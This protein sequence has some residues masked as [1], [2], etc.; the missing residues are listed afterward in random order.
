M[1]GNVRSS[2][3]AAVHPFHVITS[4][5]ISL[6]LLACGTSSGASSASCVDESTTP[7]TCDDGTKSI[8]TCTGGAFG[9]CAC[10]LTDA[11]GVDV[12]AVTDAV[13]D[14]PNQ[15]DTANQPDT[16][17]DV[18]TG[19]ATCASDKDCTAAGKVCDPLTKVCVACLTD[20]ECKVNEHC[21]GLTCQGYT[22]CTNS[23][24]CKS[25]KGP[26]GL[27][28]P[29]CDQKIGECSS[30]LTAADCPAINDCV[31]KA[32]VPYKNCQNSTEC[33]KDEV[34]DKATSRCVQ[35]L[36]N[37]DCAAS[38]L[39]ES[40]K[41]HAFVP[42]SSDKQCTPLG[43]LCDS[44][45]GKCA[46]CL[47][48]SDCPAIYNCQKVGV[49][50][51]GQCVLD[52]CAQG[53]GACNN[54]QKVTC[55]SVGDGYGSP[56]ACGNGTTCVAPGGKPECKAWV[57]TPG[58]TCEGDKL[59]TCTDDGLEVQKSEDCAASGGKC[60]GG[61]CKPIVCAAGEKFCDGKAVKL[62]AADGLSASNLSTCAGDQYCDA[63]A[64]KAQICT[65]NQDGCDGNAI[66]TC[67]AAGSGYV[68]GTQQTCGVQK[69]VAGVCK[70]LVCA[71]SETYCDGKN[72]KV[73]AADGLSATLSKTCTAS[74]FCAAG[75]CQAQVCTPGT[76]V[77]DGSKPGTCK[78]D[79]S[80]IETF[81]VD[82]ATKSPAKVCSAGS[83][84]DQ[85]CTPA[86][87]FC[88]GGSL[89]TCSPDGTAV[90]SNKPC[91]VG[92]YCGTNKLG[93]PA[94][95]QDVCDP[96]KPACNGTK[97]TTCNADGSGYAGANTDCAASGKVCSAG[98]C[99]SLL[100]DPQD[101]LYCDG[102]N[103]MKC[104]AIGLSPS[105][106]QTCGAGY[107]CASGACSKQ[108]CTPDSATECVG[109]KPA[110]C[111]SDGSG[112]AKIGAD[113]GVGKTCQAGVCSA[114][115]C[116]NGVVEVGE[117]CDDGNAWPGD[118]CDSKCKC[119]LDGALLV[120][121]GTCTLSG[122][123]INPPNQMAKVNVPQAFAG[124]TSGTVEAWVRLDATSQY[125]KI[126]YG[127]DFDLQVTYEGDV[128][129]GSN[130]GK[131]AATW[132]K[133]VVF[134]Q[135]PAA[136]GSWHHFAVV[137]NA[138]KV[139]FF[140]DGQLQG[141]TTS[142]SATTVPAIAGGT[143]TIGGS[144]NAG[145]NSNE[146]LNGAI[147]AFRV[148]TTA[149]YT[150]NFQPPSAF[151]VDAN[152]LQV[153]AFDELAGTSASDSV[154]GNGTGTLLN[155]AGWTAAGAS[156]AC[157][158]ALAK[159]SCA[160]W[161]AS[162][163][164][165]PDGVYPIDPDGAGP[166][167]AANLFCDMKNG[168]LT[169]VANIYDSAGDDAPNDTSY[170]VSGWQQTSSGA[171]ASKASTVDRA[172][173]GGTGSA[174]VS[175]AFVEALKASAG[176]ANLKM[177]FVHKD[178]YDTVC[179]DSTDGSLTLVSYATG[180]PKLTPYVNDKLT[181]TFGRLAGLAGSVDG[182]DY[183]KMS[184]NADYGIPIS[185]DIVNVFG[186]GGELV[187]WGQPSDWFGVWYA[188]GGGVCFRPSLSASDELA[189]KDG[190]ADP[191]P[192][193]F[194]FR[195]YIGP[196]AKTYASCAARLAAEPGSG[197]GVYPID[198][199]GTGPIAAANL[200]CDMKNG[201][202]TLVANIYDSAGDD[203][204]NDTSYVVSGWQQTSSGAWASK[205]STVDRAWG[206]GTGSAAVSLAFVE[207]LKASAGQANLKM[208]FVHKDGYDTVC[209]DST[210]GSLT[211]V[212]YATGNP[213]LTPY[214]N[215]KLTYTFGRLA[216]LPGTTD[217]YASAT[218]VDGGDCVFVGAGGP[219]DFGSGKQ[220][221][222][223][224]VPALSLAQPW[225]AWGWAI[226]YAPAATNAYELAG[227]T[228][229]SIGSFV[230]DQG[231][232]NFGFRL[233]VGP[234]S[235]WKLALEENFDDGMSQGFTMCNGCAGLGCP[236]VANGKYVM[237][238]DWNSFCVPVD[239]TG[240]V[241]VA[242]EFDAVFS[243][244]TEFGFWSNVAGLTYTPSQP[245]TV[246]TPAVTPATFA[247]LVNLNVHVR[248]EYDVAKQRFKYFA[249]NTLVLDS[250]NGCG[251]PN[252]LTVI[253]IGSGEGAV[254]VANKS[255]IDNFK[256]WVR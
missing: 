215:D 240:T 60:V 26:D 241:G 171:W 106:L 217:G 4:I 29:I 152:A 64:C 201:G 223:S 249:D 213:K 77:C 256:A 185:A 208:C 164:S 93:D 233:Y 225:I 74:Q 41:C 191:S 137:F 82:C 169:L 183:T 85:I 255:T 8:K 146:Q 196:T 154:A 94:C 130:Q 114:Q 124:Q 57:C 203:A 66:A 197:D 14:T 37:N 18:P 120:Q 252:P 87:Q 155:G 242:Y 253:N 168:G 51:T 63:G 116:G 149:V 98:V 47:T 44:G 111:N 33:A 187:E 27:D 79:G 52:V 235:P 157:V 144:P 167:A 24:G 200:F 17:T 67:N 220:L 204:P 61:A 11:I 145:D 211:L 9:E 216:G 133:T 177:C 202:L 72:V 48:N 75:Q 134:S 212:S 139:L 125:G 224:W 20:A 194:G 254:G 156:A 232:G 86:S 243:A 53:Q 207:A 78:T 96:G 210:D 205:A 218:Y 3:Q 118:G 129:F 179:R 45:K 122:C 188:G 12:L 65:P 121:G 19:P 150:A 95:L 22:P 238:G 209:R 30:C 59:V 76:Q 102:Q 92:N 250:G 108:V 226:G 206:G 38:E 131:W 192:T 16:T 236:T 34:C 182:Y 90:T 165:L 46:Q 158:A 97:A 162:N 140:I 123:G 84:M 138:G 132:A 173:G 99:K 13:N 119:S 128:G 163:G 117:E 221:C 109:N 113:C 166:I 21:I 112:Y 42:C 107:Y 227:F 181:Y 35:C 101:P 219:A 153:L 50:K 237:N 103:V 198:P 148:S 180:N 73:C 55:N 228:G 141:Q 36:G 49:D 172:W 6:L 62:C 127:S 25:A 214:V 5:A 251:D 199:D 89:K 184:A 222:E 190:G 246:C 68:A 234:S 159:T 39:C 160:A 195:L 1:L 88:E 244:S 7:C 100:C 147:R 135:A 176:Q 247:P 189:N 175:L 105:L 91:G 104:D 81:G 178:G 142:P 186:T 58:L 126:F 231:D 40:G 229:E 32:C 71:P 245:L 70:P 115:A 174:A 248:L 161:L 110:T 54:N 31:A 136:L 69:C 10:T 28:Q 143:M 239:L 170:V 80:G 83:C 230:P 151:A 23:L 2:V 15:P 43:L 56:Q 193:A